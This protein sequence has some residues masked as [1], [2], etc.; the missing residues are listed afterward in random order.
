MLGIVGFVVEYVA[1]T[2]GMGA[3][4]LNR[5]GGEPAVVAGPSSPIPESPYETPPTTDL[6]LTESLSG[7]SDDAV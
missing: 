2:A 7:S 4:I 1:W 5:F 3:V 6:P